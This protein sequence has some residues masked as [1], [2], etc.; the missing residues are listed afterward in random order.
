M[1]SGP[2]N[3]DS[4]VSIQIPLRLRVAERSSPEVSGQLGRVV[5]LENVA[6]HDA[7][8]IRGARQVPQP[9]SSDTR[10]AMTRLPS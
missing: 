1:S 9:V 8:L 4:A 5:I 7:E 10:W 6:R 2:I 3:W